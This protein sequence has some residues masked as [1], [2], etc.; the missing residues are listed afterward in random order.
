MEIGF[1]F[2]KGCVIKRYDCE[3]SIEGLEL[4]CTSLAEVDPD[5]EV[6]FGFVRAEK[7]SSCKA[8]SGVKVE[9]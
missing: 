3:Q 2:E 9:L 7:V 5:L 1:V 8:L 6:H 4:V